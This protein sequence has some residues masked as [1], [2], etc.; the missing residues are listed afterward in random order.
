MKKSTYIFL[1]VLFTYLLVPNNVFAITL[2]E[3]EDK[4][5]KYQNE[6]TAAQNAIK[7]TENQIT[8]TKNEIKNTQTQMQDLESEIL[9]L[10]EETENGKEE[11]KKKSLEVKALYEYLQLSEDENAYL[12]YAFGADSITD[13]IYRMSIVEQ[14]TEYNNQIIEDLENMIDRNSKREEEIKKLEEKLT[15]KQK[16]LSEKVL[17]L[18]EEKQAYEEGGVDSAKQLKIYKDIV[19]S[20]KKLGCKSNHVIGVDCAVAAS[21]GKFRR[22]TTVGS[23]T[24]EFGSR[25]GSF[26]RGIDITSPNKKKEKIY[27]VANG[28]VIAK[29]SDSYGALI[30]VLEHYDS[31]SKKWYSSLYAHMSSYA[32]GLTVGKYVTSDQYIGYMGNTGYVLPK[33]TA[34]NPTAGTHLHLEVAPCRMYKDNSCGTWSKYT[35]FVKSRA[36]RGFKG[37]RSLI[38]FP[39]GSTRWSSR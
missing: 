33:P 8:N 11:I 1:F 16:T 35:S 9:K 39:S 17:S 34:S 5:T 30:V 31:S 3:Y 27:P 24:S 13:F 23:I 32:S 21:A 26:H 37:P 29:Y 4:V 38:N 12:E 28:T 25:W 15:Q 6:L 18:G 20:Y 36:S 22:P 14:M 19:A 10:R 2:K 7:K